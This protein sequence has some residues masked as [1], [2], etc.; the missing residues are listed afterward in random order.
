MCPKGFEPPTPG[1]EGRCSIQLSYGH[2][3]C[4]L[5][6]RKRFWAFTKRVM[7]IE[8]T[9]L[10]WKASVL[11]LNYTR[12]LQYTLFPLLL[13]RRIGVTGFEPATPCSQSRCS[14]QTEP[15]PV[16][17]EEAFFVFTVFQRQ[18]LLY[19]ILFCL[20]TLFSFFIFCRCI[21]QQQVLLYIISFC[22]STL[23]SFFCF[24]FFHLSLSVSLNKM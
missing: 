2:I 5:H 3:S 12:V 4:R 6:V 8:P 24:F 17:I 13:F 1:L 16:V 18:V 10:A 21:S 23:F 9:Y 22:L 11:P 7:G 14:S 15:H 19:I 20:S